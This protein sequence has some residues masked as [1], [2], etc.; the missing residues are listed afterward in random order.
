MKDLEDRGNP[1]YRFELRAQI[2]RAGFRTLGE[3][4]SATGVDL[5]RISRV[6]RGWEWPNEKIRIA[7]SKELRISMEDLLKLL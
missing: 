6:V 2:A 4:G 7:L 3:F 1:K 5:A